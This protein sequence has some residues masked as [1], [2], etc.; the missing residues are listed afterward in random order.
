MR[1]FLPRDA[2]TYYPHWTVWMNIRERTDKY[3]SVSTQII[4]ASETAMKVENISLL[5]SATA[6]PQCI[7]VKVCNRRNCAYH[8]SPSYRRVLYEREK[9]TA[10]T[11]LS[12]SRPLLQNVKSTFSLNPPSLSTKD[13]ETF[14]VDIYFHLQKHS[15]TKLLQLR[16]QFLRSLNIKKKAKWQMSIC[17]IANMHMKSTGKRKLGR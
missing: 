17:I 2:T 10:A 9:L 5:I 15:S 14:L 6:S 3:P 8:P 12:E 7:S 11:K 4:S 1:L 13:T 16:D